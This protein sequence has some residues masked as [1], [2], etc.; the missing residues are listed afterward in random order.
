M[1]PIEQH[2]VELKVE[3]AK[4][5]AQRLPSGAH[6]ITIPDVKLGEGWNRERA[7][8][9][10]L[11]PPGYPGAKPDCFWLE[12]GG[13]RLK[14]GN[15]PDRANDS[16]PIPEVGPRGTWFSWHVQQWN[17]NRDNLVVFLNVIKQRLSPAR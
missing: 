2:I 8:V 3:C 17:P 12:P 11:A 1:T 14:N 6:L 13:V 9:L 10:F 16:N 4:A 15:L 5:T 7:D